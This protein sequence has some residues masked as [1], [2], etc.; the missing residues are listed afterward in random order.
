MKG[1]SWRVADCPGDAYDLGPWS[2]FLHVDM[3]PPCCAEC[4]MIRAIQVTGGSE[5]PGNVLVLPPPF[6]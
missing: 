4:L 1:C 5:W 2:L 6:E 3:H